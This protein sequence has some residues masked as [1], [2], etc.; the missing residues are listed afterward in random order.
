MLAISTAVPIISEAAMAKI[1]NQFVRPGAA[2]GAAWGL[3]RA[4]HYSGVIRP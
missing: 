3:K 1:V 4:F 2:S